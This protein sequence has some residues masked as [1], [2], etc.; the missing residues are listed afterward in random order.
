VLPLM[1]PHTVSLVLF[2]LLSNQKAMLSQTPF[3][4]YTQLARL[5]DG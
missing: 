1:R 3:A 5:Q 2:A 4:C